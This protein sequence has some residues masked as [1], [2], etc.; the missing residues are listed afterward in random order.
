SRNGATLSSGMCRIMSG[1]ASTAELP[2]VSLPS[3]RSMPRS[4]ED[5]TPDS[6]MRFSHRGSREATVG[7]TGKLYGGGGEGVDHSSPGASQGFGPAGAPLLRLFSTLMKNSSSPTA[8]TKLPMVVMR[9][10]VSQ[11]MPSA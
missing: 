7:M 11:P 3:D 5:T 10:S 4:T 9:L 2:M 6:P 1:S 8:S